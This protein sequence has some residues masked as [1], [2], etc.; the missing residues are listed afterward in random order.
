MATVESTLPVIDFEALLKPISEENPSGESLQYSGI[1]DEIREARRADDVSLDQG[2]WR[3]ELKTADY[4]Q[5]INSATSALSS[6]TKD[7]QICAWLT[8]AITKQHGFPGLRDGVKLLREIEETFWETCY[9]EIDEGDMEGRANAIG[10]VD[11][12][13]SLA[14][15][16]IPLTLGQGFTYNNWEESITFNIPENIESLEFDEQERVKALKTQAEAE[17]RKTGEMW[18][19]AK[20]VTNRAFCEQLNLTLQECIEELN[21]LDRTNEEKFNRN[22]MPAVRELKKSFDS[23]KI[24]VDGLLKEKREEEPDPEELSEENGETVGEDG[25]T[26]VIRKGAAVATGAIQ[27][28]QDALKR[29]GDVADYFKKAEPHSPVAYL[30]QRAVKWGNMPLEAWLQD[31]IKDEGTID[32]LRETLGISADSQ[33]SEY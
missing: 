32:S 6:Q 8:E 9:P 25:E 13:L 10:W 3:S 16:T 1:Y 31:V 26:I 2:Q 4:F 28:R 17:N 15:K 7:L 24:V 19:A 23:I 30:V 27:S 5:V 21:S 11:T 14:V 20:A 18:R 12:Y 29:L 22:Q 33:S